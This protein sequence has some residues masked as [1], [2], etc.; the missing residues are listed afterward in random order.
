MLNWQMQHGKGQLIFNKI[1]KDD[2]SV[3]MFM[4]ACSLATEPSQ[5][6]LYDNVAFFNYDQKTLSC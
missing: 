2:P 4:A 3:D 6:A 1:E 5:A